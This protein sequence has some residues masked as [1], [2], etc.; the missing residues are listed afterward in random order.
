MTATVR[1]HVPPRWRPPLAAFAMHSPFA[2]PP[3]QTRSLQRLLHPGIAQFDPVIRLQLLVKVLHVQ[4]EI[5]LPVE[6]KH[7][8]HR[9]PR[10]P[11]GPGP[12]PAPARQSVITKLLVAFP[13]TSRV[14]VADP[15]DL[16]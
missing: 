8:L 16:R 1:V 10:Y 5:R 3:H 6:C 9:G 13:P 14:S 4:I 12:A 15:D 11:S 7:L 2:S